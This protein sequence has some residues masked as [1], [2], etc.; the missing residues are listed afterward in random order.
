MAVEPTQH[1]VDSQRIPI[2][3]WDWGNESAPTL[4]FVHGGRDHAR[5]WDHM[6]EAFRDDYHVVALDLRG[7]GDSGWSVGGSYGLPD[8]AIDVIRVIETVGSPARVVAHSYGGAVSLVA[9]GTF[10]EHIVAMTV[11]EGTHSLNPLDE[12]RVGPSWV[13]S[14]ADK[15]REFETSKPYVY[16]DLAAAIER[17]RVANPKLSDDILPGLAAYASKPYEGGLIWKYDWWVNSR[18]S[19]ELRRDELPAFWEAIP[20]P[21]LLLMGG[22][23]P[24]RRRQYKN[25]EQHFRDVRTIEIP[26]A[27]HWIHHDQPQ[28]ELDAIKPFFAETAK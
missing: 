9:A 7:H 14:W 17:M 24:Q 10:P 4:L 13:R 15:L 22:D 3:Y 6:A 25:P 21:V 28:A 8:N 27:G 16:P 18:T 11:I 5:S 2:S 20:F 26:D 12:E 1:F 19:M 23:S